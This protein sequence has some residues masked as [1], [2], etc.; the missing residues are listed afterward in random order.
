MLSFDEA[1]T[2]LLAGV[3]PVLDVETLPTL[4]A[5]GRVLAE[6]Q[7]ATQ[8]SPP[9]DNSAM[10]GYAVRVVDF[11]AQGAKPPFRL[12]VTQRIVAGSVGT[13]LEAGSAARVFTGAVLPPGADA[14]VMQELCADEDQGSVLIK[15]L[16][17]VGENVR[18]LGSDIAAG[19]C[20]LKVGQ[21]L[22][23]QDTGLL[24]SVGIGQVPLFR[25]V[26]VAVFFTGDELY[27][28]GEPLPPGAIYNSNRFLLTAL[29]ERL[30]C[31]V[32]DFGQVPDNLQ[33]T[34]DALREAAR[35]S[36]LIL[37][38]G[39]VSVGDADYIKPALEAEGQLALWKIAIKP[40]KPLAFGSVRR[41]DDS[42]ATV[43]SVA[44]IG[45][46]GN[47]VASFVTFVMLV[48]PVLLCLQGVK[49]STKENRLPLAYTL[50]A[51]FDWPQPDARREFLR[52]RV[53][54]EG[55]LDLFP[56]QGSSVLTSVTWA[57]G[58]LDNPPQQ[59]IRRGDMVRF[60]PFSELLN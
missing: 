36:D 50:R 43:R 58:L 34:R 22:R 46:P 10:D 51:D 19:S 12:R 60:L 1:L 6:A 42:A 18:Y 38:S 4:N 29:L 37:T 21:R 40:G 31:E 13:E 9:Q 33:A 25:R 16:P 23:P 49:D 28:P 14:V 48:R 59:M 27:M 20:V 7:Y 57:D 30:G 8:N 2:Q 56:E 54:A 52:V 3:D 47:P 32:R 45:L 44:F 55:G 39:G 35:G 11:L 53:N 41:A 24:A 26:R 17:Q 5:A 15:H